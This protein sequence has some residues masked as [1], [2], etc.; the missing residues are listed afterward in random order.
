V[1]QLKQEKVAKVRQAIELYEE[2]VNQTQI[3]VQMGVA[4]ST[5]RSWIR[6]YRGGTLQITPTGLI[7]S[8]QEYHVNGQELVK[9]KKKPKE[10]RTVEDIDWQEEAEEMRRSSNVPVKVYTE[11]PVD[12]QRPV[13][14]SEWDDDDKEDVAEMWKRAE[15]R[16]EKAV[17]RV[18]HR[19]R[20]HTDLGDDEPI[21]IS[22]ISDQHIDSGSAVCLKRMREDAELIKETPN[23]YALLGGDG[24]DNHIRHR[25][26]V[27]AAR[28]QPTDQ[29]KMY[30][31]YL[32]IFDGK[33]LAMIS[34][35]HDAWTFQHAGV[36]MVQ[37]IAEAQKICYA[38]AEAHMDIK[39]GSYTYKVSF[40]HQ[41][42]MNSSFNET[43]SV[44]QWLRHGE[45]QFDVGCVCHHHT[46][47]MEEALVAG[48]HRFFCR[49]GSYQLTSH[50]SRQYGYNLTTPT[51]PSVVLYPNERKM[52]GFYNIRDA[53]KWVRMELG[54]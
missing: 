22:F 38:P 7:W 25:A 34:G 5:V 1:N 10:G 31:H 49:P 13:V 46:P 30:D 17:K 18:M 52:V 51:C 16:N 45:V 37:R 19:A 6:R 3:G 14:T 24:V 35:N 28:S 50:Y 36:D 2:G 8:G 41:Y 40:R 29:W 42:R 21:V 33:I 4:D 20:F 39:M 43:H 23:V 47:A 54:R 48:Q 53:V 9:A 11:E 12:K 27:L 26:A 44:K 15:A 32:Q